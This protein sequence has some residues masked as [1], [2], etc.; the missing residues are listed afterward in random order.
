MR[1]AQL[2]ITDS[3]SVVD[4]L[5]LAT[6]YDFMTCSACWRSHVTHWSNASTL[7][8]ASCVVSVRQDTREPMNLS[9]VLSMPPRTNKWRI[10]TWLL[11]SSR[12]IYLFV[13]TIFAL[14]GMPGYWRVP[15]KQR[16]LS[17]A[18]ALPQQPC[19]RS[20]CTQYS[21]IHPIIASVSFAMS[22]DSRNHPIAPSVSFPK[23]RDPTTVGRV[24]LV[25]LETHLLAAA[26]THDSVRPRMAVK[27]ATRTPGVCAGL[28]SNSLSARWAS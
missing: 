4:S 17:T 15:Y 18:H 26:G 22:R 10:T 5:P 20:L 27:S 19:K 14:L 8:V 24:I 7:R 25:L 6:R 23:C 21:L 13:R 12:E 11:T 3:K 9:L 2:L 16:R 28:D 1:W